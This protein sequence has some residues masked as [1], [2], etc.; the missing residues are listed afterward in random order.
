MLQMMIG[1]FSSD[2]LR[3]KD[4]FKGVKI[5]KKDKKQ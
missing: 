2:I 5:M 3:S 4:K 1:D